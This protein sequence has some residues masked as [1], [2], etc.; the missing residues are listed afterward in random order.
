MAMHAASDES[1]SSWGAAPASLPPLVSG[2]SDGSV[3]RPTATVWPNFPRAVVDRTSR[4]SPMASLVVV[5]R[6]RREPGR[7]DR[8]RA[9]R[10]LR[11]LSDDLLGRRGGHFDP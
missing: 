7:R 8:Q 5:V 1:S 6:R 10:A 9:R 4:S 3:W 2:S 11:D